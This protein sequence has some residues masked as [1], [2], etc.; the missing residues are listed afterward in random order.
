MSCY[1]KQNSNKYSKKICS[2]LQTTRLRTVYISKQ[3]KWHLNFSLTLIGIPFGI[4]F[5]F[6]FFGKMDV[7]FSKTYLPTY[8]IRL[9]P[10]LPETPTQKLDFHSMNLLLWKIRMLL[11]KW[12]GHIVTCR[13]LSVTPLKKLFQIEIVKSMTFATQCT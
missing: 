3:T 4:F 10:I 2:H 6:R 13:I 1:S 12:F 8:L 7:H 9:C 11:Q 5:F